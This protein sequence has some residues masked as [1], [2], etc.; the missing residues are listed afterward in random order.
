MSK[1]AVFMAGQAG[2]IM[3]A[4]SVLKY[5]KEV[6]GDS[7]IVW[8]V[9]NDN[10]DLLKYQDIELRE[11]PRGFGYPKMV[12]E[13]NK[14]FIDAG[15]EPIWEDWE[16]LVNE[17][18]QM[19][20]ELKNNYP[21]LNDIT[22]GYFPAPHQI[23][24]EKRHNISYP[25]C[26]K[27]VF[28]IP[29]SYE[30]HP[31]LLFSDEERKKVNDFIARMGNGKR[32]IFETFAGSSQSILSEDMVF[33][34]MEICNDHWPNCNFIFASH[35]FLRGHESFPDSLRGRSNVF[36]ASNFTVR[37]CGLIAEQTD[38]MISVS[39]GITVAASAWGLIQPPTAQFC[40]SFICSTKTLSHCRFELVTA[41]DKTFENAK[42][43]FYSKLIQLLNE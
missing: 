6:F 34:T 8:F 36:F 3:S 19:N 5:R 41:D 11:F 23:S 31:V 2:D 37:Q 15:K 28:G 22:E 27:M 35:K 39:S 32:I 20:P 42:D 25:D 12:Y 40:G 21:S 9:S 38:L 43:E 4:M 1:Q 30:W 18:N 24:V 33:K 17:K 7:E 10:R 26:S 16:P 13:E 14:K 29:N